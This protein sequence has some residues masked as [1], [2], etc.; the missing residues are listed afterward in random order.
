MKNKSENKKHLI[1]KIVQYV[2]IVLLLVA[3]LGFYIMNYFSRSKGISLLELGLTFVI[4]VCT[5]I[6]THRLGIIPFFERMSFFLATV[7]LI[8]FTWIVTLPAPEPLPGGM[9]ESFKL[10]VES[11]GIL[12]PILF[13]LVLINILDNDKKKLTITEIIILILSFGMFLGAIIAPTFVYLLRYIC[14]VGLFVVCCKR[15]T[16]VKAENGTLK[17]EILQFVP[18]LIC[19]V[20]VIYLLSYRAYYQI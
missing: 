11:V 8:P 7:P 18:F 12:L 2:I 10:S 5:G 9:G 3:M 20:R 6:Y 19:A 4:V 16:Y 17:Y 13:A 15:W 1:W 14:G